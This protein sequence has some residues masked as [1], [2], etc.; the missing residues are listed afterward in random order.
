MNS[1]N[2]VLIAWP[3]AVLA[4]NNPDALPRLATVDAYLVLTFSSIVF[5]IVKDV[6]NIFVLS[7][8]RFV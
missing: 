8:G 4:Q 3:L 7:T 6:V 2:F 5:Q 1:L